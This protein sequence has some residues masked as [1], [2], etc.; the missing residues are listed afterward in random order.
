[1]HVQRLVP[2]A[3]LV[4]MIVALLCGCG[5][6]GQMADRATA[7]VEPLSTD[8]FRRQLEEIERHAEE[9]R[10]RLEQKR[11]HRRS[12]LRVV[13]HEIDAENR[14]VVSVTNGSNKAIDDIGGGFRVEDVEGN[15]ITGSGFIEA[16]PGSVYLQAGETRTQVPFVSRKP[17]LI[18]RLRTEPGALRFAFEARSITWADGSTEPDLGD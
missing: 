11:E 4:A 5:A 1:M 14:V 6:S 2:L 3:G 16:V 10:I 12:F 18:E 9:D 8:D 7:Q 17:E 15:Y 13:F